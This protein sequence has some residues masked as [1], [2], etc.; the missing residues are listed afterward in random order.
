MRFERTKKPKCSLHKGFSPWEPGRLLME[1]IVKP[2]RERKSFVVTTS[3][4]V[5][6]CSCRPKRQEQ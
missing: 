5:G 1:E 4:E 6:S 2:K 3:A